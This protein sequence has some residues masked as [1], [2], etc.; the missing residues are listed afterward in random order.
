VLQ[1]R[2]IEHFWVPFQ[3]VH[4][5]ASRDLTYVC[6]TPYTSEHEGLFILLTRSLISLIISLS[7]PPHKPLNSL[8]HHHHQARLRAIKPTHHLPESSYF[9]AHP[10]PR[11]QLQP[12]IPPFRHPM[13]SPS[14]FSRSYPRNSLLLLPLPQALPLAI[15]TRLPFAAQ[16]LFQAS[17]I[18]LR[19]QTSHQTFPQTYALHHTAQVQKEQQ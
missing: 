11:A 12:R 10:L 2:E 1:S 5:I 15:W 9:Y 13:G 19:S 3:N 6:T 8:H 17:F 18:F 4:R 7:L 14:T 16:R